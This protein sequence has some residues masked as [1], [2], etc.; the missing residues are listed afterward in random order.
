M[1]K[2]KGKY[3]CEKFSFYTTYKY[4]F[5]DFAKANYFYIALV[6]W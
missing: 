1:Q 6:F 5:L 2:K 4:I 3:F